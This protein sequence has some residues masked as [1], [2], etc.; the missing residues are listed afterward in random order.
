MRSLQQRVK[1]WWDI[2]VFVIGFPLGLVFLFFFWGFLLKISTNPIWIIAVSIICLYSAVILIVSTIIA[3][4]ENNIFVSSFILLF[5]GVTI[6][7]LGYFY[8]QQSFQLGVDK[9]VND[10]Y[11]NISTELISVV[12]TVLAIETIRERSHWR[13][14]Q[15]EKQLQEASSA[16]TPKQNPEKD[17]NDESPQQ[18]TNSNDKKAEIPWGLFIGIVIGLLI[19]SN[20]ENLKQNKQD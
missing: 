11:A 4:S 6:G 18:K 3:I 14:Y 5:I 15:R 2:W 9:L 19:R 7:T 17:G 1:Q 8:S 13:N 20:W 10:F 16:T 12:I